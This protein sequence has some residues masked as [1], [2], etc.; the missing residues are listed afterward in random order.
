MDR[1]DGHRRVQ[2]QWAK[3]TLPPVV[4]MSTVPCLH[5]RACGTRRF[6]FELVF[7][8]RKGALVF[9]ATYLNDPFLSSVLALCSTV[10]LWFAAVL[11]KPTSK[12]LQIRT[13]QAVILMMQTLMMLQAGGRVTPAH[14]LGLH[15]TFTVLLLLIYCAV[16]TS[17][18][19][20]GPSWVHPLSTM[21]VCVCVS[22][23]VCLHV[24]CR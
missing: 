17:M 2:S 11:V 6:L 24:G 3:V 22:L 15:V 4:V 21:C 23:R 12:Q 20:R 13:L 10:L 7:L 9:L 5:Q 18:V 1:G 8:L 19:V 14:M 16:L